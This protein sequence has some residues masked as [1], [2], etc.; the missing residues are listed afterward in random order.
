MTRIVVAV[1]ALAAGVTLVAVILLGVLQQDGSLD[2]WKEPHRLPADSAAVDA[3]AKAPGSVPPPVPARPADVAARP[4]RPIPPPP[5]TITPTAIPAPVAVR[6]REE[7]ARGPGSV[8]GLVIDQS[9]AWVAKA[10][11]WIHSGDAERAAARTD[12]HGRFVFHGLPLGRHRIEVEPP[13]KDAQGDFAIATVTVRLETGSEVAR[14]RIVVNRGLHVRGVVVGPDGR[15]VAGVPVIAFGSREDLFGDLGVGTETGR[16]GSFRLG[17]L[18]PGRLTVQADGSDGLADSAPRAVTAGAA[19]IVLRLPRAASL[20]GIA[21]CASRQ[22]STACEVRAYKRERW[23]WERAWTRR[24]DDSF[25]FPELEP[26][27]Y[28]LVAVDVAG[29]AGVRPGVRVAEGAKLDRVELQLTPGGSIRLH[30]EGSDLGPR[31]D[32]TPHKWTVRQRGAIVFSARATPDAITAVVP[33]GLTTVSLVRLTDEVVVD[34]RAISALAGRPV[35][36][37]VPLP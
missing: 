29:N 22:L 28:D 37:R 21:V 17:P 26:G 23:V 1:A 19:G 33:A 10:C 12:D 25:R 27:V 8:L 20:T 16:D 3:T 18:R 5:P 32:E 35:Q 2:D 31:L 11:V 6:S 24:A 15:P 14:P 7:T 9:G 36:V 13:R 30:I 34:E 4:P